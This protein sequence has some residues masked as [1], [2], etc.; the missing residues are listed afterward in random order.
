MRA[1]VAFVIIWAVVINLPAQ[2]CG[3]TDP[4]ATN[5]NIAAEVNDGSCLYSNETISPTLLG[6]LPDQLSGT[7]S[8]IYWDGAYWT[9]N[10]HSNRNLYQLDTVSGQVSDSIYFP[11]IE[12]YDTEEVSQDSLYLYFGDFGNNAGSRTD[13]RIYRVSK[14]AL[15][16][17]DCRA[18]TIRFS[19][20]DQT[21]FTSSAQATDYDCEAFVVGRDSIYLFTKQWVSGSTVCYSLPKEPGEQIATPRATLAVDGLVTGATY[22]P[23]KRIVVLCGYSSQL[24]PFVYLLYDFRDEEFFSGNK[25]KLNFP[26]TTRDQVE[27]VAS[28]NGVNYYITNEY[29]VYQGLIT[30]VPKFQHIDLEPYL[31]GYIAS[32]SLEGADTCGVSSEAVRNGMRLRIV[33]TPADREITLEVETDL[34]GSTYILS[35]LSGRMVARGILRGN[36]M[37]LPSRIANGQYLL[38]VH[39]QRGIYC[40]KI[41][42]N[43]Y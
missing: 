10:D 43:R 22:L 32:L 37:R 26:A 23:N 40:G 20:I 5:Y 33:P 14:S 1:F 16:D 28:S 13:L 8:L 41:L 38:R 17:G 19:Y 4:L 30:R 7:S 29:F 9:Y 24:R 25:R 31:G 15:F 34:R 27:A 39:A 11:M 42:I 3:C 21:D 6:T 35:D 2:I 18:D 12:N 36:E